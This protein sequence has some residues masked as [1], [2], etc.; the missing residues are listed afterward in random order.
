MVGLMNIWCCYLLLIDVELPESCHSY[1][2]SLAQDDI[3]KLIHKGDL[4]DAVSRTAPDGSSWRSG[5]NFTQPVI[6][7][8]LFGEIDVQYIIYA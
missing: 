3:S 7:C 2:Q 1:D 8:D 5:Q 6:S 4:T